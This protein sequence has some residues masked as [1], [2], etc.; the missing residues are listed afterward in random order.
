MNNDFRIILIDNT[1]YLNQSSGNA[2][3]K[4]IEEPN[5]K[6]IFILVHDISYKLLDTIK[7][8]VLFSK[9]CFHVK[10]QFQSLKKS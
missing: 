6:L 9:R 2:L 4:I 3:L 5:E 1:E 8:D 10:K 7:S